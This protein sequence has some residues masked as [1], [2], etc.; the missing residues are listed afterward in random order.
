MKGLGRLGCRAFR[1]EGLAL[2]AVVGLGYIYIY[3]YIYISGRGLRFVLPGLLRVE[4]LG[5]KI[6]GFRI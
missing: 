4:G 3:I 5:R 2:S 1:G 6:W